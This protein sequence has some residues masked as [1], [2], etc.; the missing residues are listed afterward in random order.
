M[1]FEVHGDALNQAFF[2]FKELADR[3]MEITEADLEALVADEISSEA[4][5][6]YS[7]VEL[8]VGGGTVG[9]PSARVVITK[10]NE[11]REARAE[12]NGMIDAAGKAI[13]IATG[14]QTKLIGFT[15]SSVTGG[16]DAQGEVVV[17]LESGEFKVS[18]RG[19]STDVVEAS[20]RAYLNAVNRLARSMARKD[21]RNTEVG[22]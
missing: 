22:P 19:V 3:K 6:I 2:R 18:G 17:Q 9:T 7:L 20:T 10:D 8:E 11:R 16:E 4:A 12:G 13:Q 21:V 15:V 1:G 14:I 5:N